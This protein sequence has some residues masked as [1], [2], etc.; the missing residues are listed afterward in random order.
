MARKKVLFIYVFLMV[1]IILIPWWYW[2][3]SVQDP[4]TWRSIP[5]RDYLW[6]F[7]FFIQIGH[8]RMLYVFS[9]VWTSWGFPESIPSSIQLWLGTMGLSYAL[10]LF[11]ALYL[12]FGLVVLSFVFLISGI[13]R[14]SM[15]I[16]AAGSFL[17]LIAPLIFYSVLHRYGFTETGQILWIG[18]FCICFLLSAIGFI[19]A[20]L[21]WRERKT[22]T[23]SQNIC[24]SKE[25]EGG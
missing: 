15:G 25:T 14:E 17:L 16:T 3:G 9:F 18:G 21:V 13:F 19:N 7:G 8:I 12:V 2:S 6:P 5:R 23:P 4:I 20:Y 11:P 24:G 1:L 10:L 22:F